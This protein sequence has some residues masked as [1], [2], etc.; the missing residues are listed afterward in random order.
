MDPVTILAI[1]TGARAAIE[2]A[3]SLAN[4]A[5]GSGEITADQLEE[6][7]LRASLA[8]AEWDAIVAAAKGQTNG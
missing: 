7:K 5:F 8:D 2:G 3:V 6:I 1:I 4:V